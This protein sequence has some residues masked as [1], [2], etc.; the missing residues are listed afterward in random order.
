[1]LF[2]CLISLTPRTNQHVALKILTADACD[3]E[4]DTFELDILRHMQAK[5]QG[6]GSVVGSDKV[7][8]LL[9]EFSHTGPNGRHTCL[10]FKPMGPDMSHFRSLFHFPRI[11]IPVAKKVSRDLLMSLAFLHDHCNIIHTG[12]FPKKDYNQLHKSI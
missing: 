9:D 11:P 12:M 7:L 8:G 1:M 6:A 5:S 10:V 4:N 2:F 3:G